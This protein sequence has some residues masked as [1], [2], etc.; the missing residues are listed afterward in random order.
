MLQTTNRFLNRSLRREY[1]MKK[2]LFIRNEKA[3]LP[4]IEAYIQYFNKT[5]EFIAYDSS[6]LNGDF[7]QNEYDILWEFKGVGGLKATDQIL[8]HEYASLSTG[9]FPVLKNAVKT[10]KNRKPNL[11]VFLNANVK[12]GFNFKDTI[13]Y[14]YRDMGI[15]R[16]FLQ[17]EMQNKEFDF[18][19]IGSISKCREIDQLLHAFTTKMKGKLLLIGPADDDLYIAYKNN[20]DITFTGKVRYNEV[21]LIAST[22][23]YGINFIPNR[24]PFNIQTSTKLL[25]YVA[26]GLKV[27]TTDYKWVRQ[28]EQQHNC[29]FFK[30]NINHF[31]HSQLE[32]HK[33]IS[34]M[35]CEDFLWE[36]VIDR[37]NILQKIIELGKP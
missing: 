27:I 19:Y 5:K 29:S 3:F 33:F 8:I 12:S 22:A 35:N 17:N 37:S 6:K 25:E 7:D 24:Y 30:L 36:N 1:Y 28:F 16:I 9:T 26:L 23:E 4:E 20:K 14:C 18:V 10:L 13:P 21:P 2:M 31:E 15:D 34:N 11:R 32:K